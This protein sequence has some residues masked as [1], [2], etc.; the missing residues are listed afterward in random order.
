MTKNRYKSLDEFLS[1][2]EI[3]KNDKVRLKNSGD[4]GIV[5]DI[6]LNT[7]MVI[8]FI[9]D[10]NDT[11]ETNINDI[12]LINPKIEQEEEKKEKSPKKSLMGQ[13]GNYEQ[14]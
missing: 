10:E 13:L 14:D 11:I 8:L 9:E 6:N 1:E 7:R 5:K 2:S 3:K 12:E 4:I